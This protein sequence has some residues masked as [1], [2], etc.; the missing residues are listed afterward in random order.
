MRMYQ[1]PESSASG[2]ANRGKG[3][4]D[5][6]P[7]AACQPEEGD[8]AFFSRLFRRPQHHCHSRIGSPQNTSARIT[9]KMANPAVAEKP[10]RYSSNTRAKACASTPKAPEPAAANAAVT[11]VTK[12]SPRKVNCS[13]PGLAAHCP[14]GPRFGVMVVLR[15]RCDR[16]S[17]SASPRAGTSGL[18][19]RRARRSRIRP[20]G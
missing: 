18:G 3:K 13:G 12:N 8:G 17:T 20:A 4:A 11:V 2:Q 6:C 16:C 1:S 14:A 15:V 9:M 19:S 5:F 10:T 7:A